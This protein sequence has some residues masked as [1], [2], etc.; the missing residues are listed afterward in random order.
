MG[1]I[2]LVGW[3]LNGVYQINPKLTYLLYVN[4]IITEC[5]QT[6]AFLVVGS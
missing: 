2:M 6:K 3:V 1:N 5:N 4:C